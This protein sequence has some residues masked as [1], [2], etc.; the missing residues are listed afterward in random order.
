MKRRRLDMERRQTMVPFTMIAVLFS[1]ELVAQQAPGAARDEAGEWVVIESK[2]GPVSFAMPG[3]PLEHVT[4]VQ[5]PIGKIRTKAYIWQRG[6]EGL[7]L[8]HDTLPRAGPQNMAARAME[9]ALE[10]AGSGKIEIVSKAP[11]N[12]SGASGLEVVAKEPSPDGK[13]KATVRMHMLERGAD[14]YLLVAKSATGK[15]LPPEAA[16]FFNSI[17]FD[18]KPADKP[19][20]AIA[21]AKAAMAKPAAPIAAA[22]V[23]PAKPAPPAKRKLIGK[24]DRVDTTAES[25]LRTFVMAMAAGDEETLREVSLPNP[26]LD[27]LL[28]G[29]ATPVRG[30]KE[31]KQQII[32]ARVDRLKE[33]DRVKIT[34]KEVHA[35]RAAE[36]A[37]DHAAL[38]IDGT[39]GYAPLERIKGR[40]KVDPAPFIAARKA[41]EIAK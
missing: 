32:K 21:G 4:E 6:E 36:V 30:I 23:A 15:P 22:K 26:D 19:A 41:A 8:R 12:V 9:A 5:S 11:I 25:A 29:E 38:K 33:G 3:K 39:P 18:G 24:I 17:R 10:K 13:G 2:E 28:R 34:G 14:V 31:L 27:W 7:F 16:G 37:R 20:I 40:W 1:F 35:I